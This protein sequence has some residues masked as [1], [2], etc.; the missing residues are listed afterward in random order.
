MVTALS[1]GRYLGAT[2]SGDDRDGRVLSPAVA[3]GIVVWSASASASYLL[4]IFRR[5]TICCGWRRR[6]CR[7]RSIR[8][9]AE[10]T[11]LAIPGRYLA[12]T[13]SG[14]DRDGRVL[15]PA[16]A[17]GIVVW[18]ASS[19]IFWSADRYCCGWRRRCCRIRSIRVSAERTEL[20]QGG[21]LQRRAAGTIE[22]VSL[23]PAVSPHLCSSVEAVEANGEIEMECG[24]DFGMQSKKLPIL[25]FLR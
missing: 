18:S 13:S 25:Q 12:A 19:R 2:S 5:R 22:M 21:I 6:C 24:C 9:S 15:S 4:R 11:E 17:V 3:V 14:D 20:F 10:R 16:V 1:Q 7:I 8:V 23:S